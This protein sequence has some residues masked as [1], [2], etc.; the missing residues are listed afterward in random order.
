MP[1]DDKPNPKKIT[2][3]PR[4]W[5]EIESLPEEEKKA[6]MEIVAIFQQAS[7][8]LGEGATEEEFAAELERLSG[9]RVE[10]ID[11]DTL[12]DKTRER[13]LKHA[14]EPITKH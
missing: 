1:S 3:D 13:L 2:V 7:D 12:D 10:K 14:N 9:G 5:E 4:V 8:N 11:P 6:F